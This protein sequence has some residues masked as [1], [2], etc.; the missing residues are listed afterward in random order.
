MSD[1]A[2][3]QELTIDASGT[4]DGMA[5]FTEAMQ[6]VEA[7]LEA[8]LEQMSGATLAWKNLGD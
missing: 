3:V 4:Q 7:V 5:I 6:K 1:T 8:M 2:V